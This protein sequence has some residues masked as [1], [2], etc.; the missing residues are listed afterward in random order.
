[1]RI[2]LRLSF[3]RQAK[4]LEGIDPDQQKMLV[5]MLARMLANMPQVNACE[6]VDEG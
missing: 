6:S 3:A 5:G 4:L 1:M 2:S